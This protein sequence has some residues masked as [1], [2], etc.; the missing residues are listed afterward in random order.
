MN[1]DKWTV[2]NFKN[3]LLFAIKELDNI[4]FDILQLHSQLFQTLVDTKNSELSGHYITIISMASMKQ[5]K[6]FCRM[7]TTNP[8]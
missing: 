7:Q 4:L 6:L 3:N 1:V 5:Y 8:V 2:F